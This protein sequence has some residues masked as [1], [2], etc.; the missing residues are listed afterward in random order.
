VPWDPLEDR[1]HGEETGSCPVVV[2]V[3]VV[4]MMMMMMI[5]GVEV[6]RQR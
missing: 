2:V 3:V 1:N 6:V 5:M 4:V